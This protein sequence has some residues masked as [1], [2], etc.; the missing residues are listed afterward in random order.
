MKRLLS[1][2]RPLRLVGI[3]LLAVALS[4]PLSA[5]ARQGTPP[6]QAHGH[7]YGAWSYTAA[8]IPDHGRLEASVRYDN[9]SVTGLRAYAAANQF[10]AGQFARAGGTVEVQ[11]TFRTPMAPDAFRA[12]AT[13]AGL[14]VQAA[15]IRTV[16]A[17]GRRSTLAVFPRGGDPLPQTIID[18]QLARHQPAD[19][20]TVQGVVD[21]RGTVDAARLPGIA[22][23]AKVFMA[24]VTAT[25]VRSD[26]ASEGEVDAAQT[27][28]Q[29]PPPFWA[30]EDL[31]L[32]NFR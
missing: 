1:T 4:A 7:D 17:K 26:L 10:L 14:T 27:L 19:P 20:L 32:V 8:R 23:D 9:G 22:A 30:M 28:V 18:R 25:V 12:W 5:H 13:N 21:A 15:D 16:N 2:H 29:V 24:D 6:P 11:V 3:C 31:G